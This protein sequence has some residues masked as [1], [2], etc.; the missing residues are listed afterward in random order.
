MKRLLLA[1]LIGIL[2]V[3]SIGAASA[4]ASTSYRVIRGDTLYGIAR[5]YG[6][7][8]VQ[9]AQANGLTTSSWVYTG[10]VLTIP[11]PGRW[12]ERL[13]PH[14]L[15]QPFHPLVVDRIALVL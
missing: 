2:V 11:G 12:T 5:R 8:V 3:V 15:H 1:M 10:Q 4:D 13:Q 9:L 14:L 6:V 7:S